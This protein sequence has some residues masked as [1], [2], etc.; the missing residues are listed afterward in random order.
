M[1][2]TLRETSRMTLLKEGLTI[3]S[4]L[5]V[6][7]VIGTI[8]VHRY[9][10][11]GFR[12]A[13]REAADP[14]WAIAGG[15]FGLLL[16]FMVVILWDGLQS[17]QATVQDEA[18]DLVNLYQLS[19]GLPEAANAEE[20]RTQIRSYTAVLVDEEWDALGRH[21]QSEAA[22]ERLDT[23][24]RSYMS[25]E[26]RLGSSSEALNQSMARL[27]ELQ[28]ARNRRINEAKSRVPTALWVVLVGGVAIV[29]VMAWFTGSENFRTHLLTTV[30]LTVSLAAVLFLIRILNNP[31]QG[32]IRA[33][34]EPMER[35]L[36][37]FDER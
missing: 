3:L 8:L 2:V 9:S 30:V 7:G 1:A 6:P 18:N 4:L 5:L 22:E 13:N 11:P 36:A 10:P 37:H 25:L 34:P 24:W 27:A 26:Q 12:L 21:E 35:A 28:D 20:L 32:A 14:V 23:I 15:A 16:G 31:F 29:I 19:Y 33:D 17:A